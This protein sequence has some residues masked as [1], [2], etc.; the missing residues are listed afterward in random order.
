MCHCEAA[1]R[2]VATHDRVT[3]SSDVVRAYLLKG[4]FAFARND[5]NLFVIIS[6]RLLRHCEE[7][8]R[9]GNP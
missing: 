4:C 1:K 6:R 3:A 9:R 2:S 5:T 8:K 7:R